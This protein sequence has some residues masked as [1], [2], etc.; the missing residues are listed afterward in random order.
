MRKAFWLLILAAWVMLVSCE[1]GSDRTKHIQTLYDETF[2]VNPARQ[3]DLS[4]SLT[5][6]D[7]VVGGFSVRD[8]GDVDFYVFG[9]RNYHEGHR[10]SAHAL[11]CAPGAVNLDY[12]FKMTLTDTAF[13]VF[14]NTNPDTLRRV[15]LLVRR[16]YWED[17]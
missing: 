7:S 3:A 13:F 2:S 16:I 6:D 4:F 9:S 17:N 1:F 5:Q 14:D 8:S 11:V 10:D 15:T 12:R